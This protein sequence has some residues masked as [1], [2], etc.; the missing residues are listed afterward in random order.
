ML[1]FRDFINECL[2]LAHR[3]ME[4]RL[5]YL[6]WPIIC[7]SAALSHVEV[8]SFNNTAKITQCYGR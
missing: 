3:L 5:T 2:G 8:F 1:S 7:L 4:L 6:P